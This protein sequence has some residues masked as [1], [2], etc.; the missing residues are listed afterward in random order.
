MHKAVSELIKD[1]VGEG[2]KRAPLKSVKI[3]FKF[4]KAKSE[5]LKKAKK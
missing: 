5:A 3:K 4:Q 2:E 1:E